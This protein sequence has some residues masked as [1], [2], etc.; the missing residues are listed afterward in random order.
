[1]IIRRLIPAIL[2]LTPLLAVAQPKYAASTMRMAERSW[3]FGDIREADGVVSHV[4]TFTNTGDKP[5]VIESVSTTCGCTKPRFS[6]APILP[7]KQSSIEISYDPTGRPGA[8]RRDITIVSNDRANINTIT[9][10][11]NVI[12][13]PQPAGE[14]FPYECGRYMRLD[15]TNHAMGYVGWGTTKAVVFNVYN[16]TGLEVPISVEPVSERSWFKST[17]SSNTIMPD[18]SVAVTLSLTP[19]SQ[20]AYGMVSGRYY[21]NVDGARCKETISVNAVVVDDFSNITPDERAQAPIAAVTPTYYNFGEM[22]KGTKKIMPLNIANEGVSLLIVR[23]VVYP[24]GVSGDLAGGAIIRSGA[25]K[26][27]NITVTGTTDSPDGKLR[28]S[29]IV[30]LN[31]PGS[32]MVDVRVSAEIID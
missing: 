28:K 20:R 7:G 24:E 25:S 8:F 14:R 10:S 12:S 22:R 26:V 3:N 19:L 5:F 1:M 29:I 11:G 2:L 32:P 21:I 6:R 4:F 15:K 23:S 31:A 9:I 30:I 18:S 13:A 16:G 17:V 27:F